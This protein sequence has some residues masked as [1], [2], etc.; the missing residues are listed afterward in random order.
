V[1]G[2]AAVGAGLLRDRALAGGV[3]AKAA[4]AVAAFDLEPMARRF[5][6]ALKTV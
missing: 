4:R 6:Q 1:E 5:R 3:T 2:A